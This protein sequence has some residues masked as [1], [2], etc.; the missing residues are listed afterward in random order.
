[1][2]K[3]SPHTK[4][5][6]RIQSIS[7]SCLTI[8]FVGLLSFSLS[9]HEA[10]AQT[11]A[12][13]T[14][15]PGDI[16][17]T[18]GNAGE[19]EDPGYA[20][21]H[22]A[23]VALRN[24][25]GGTR[26]GFTSSERWTGTGW[27]N[28]N[29]GFEG[30]VWTAPSG[31]IME[32]TEV[33][34]C[35]INDGTSGIARK[36]T[37]DSAIYR[38]ADYRSFIGGV[39]CGTWESAG[40]T[41]HLKG[42]HMWAYQP[43]DGSFLNDPRHLLCMGSDING[44]NGQPNSPAN[45]LIYDADN[46][47]GDFFD[48][49][50]SVQSFVFQT[51]Q[52]R[53]YGAV[54]ASP[55]GLIENG[56]TAGFIEML[57]DVEVEEA[58]QNEGDGNGN[59]GGG[60]G[61]G[62]GN[63]GNGGNTGNGG[64][65][66]SYVYYGNYENGVDSLNIGEDYLLF[67]PNG[68]FADYEGNFAWDSVLE[69]TGDESLDIYMDAPAAKLIVTGN[70][71]DS[72]IV[73]NLTVVNGTFQACD[74]GGKTAKIL[75]NITIKETGVY[76]GGK[77][78]LKITGS[79]QQ[80]LDASNY[81][82]P[83]ASNVAMKDVRLSNTAGMKVK[84]HVKFKAG[85]ALEF[86]Q[87]TFVEI[88]DDPNGDGTGS[89]N[90][91]FG[92]NATGTACIGP[93]DAS[94]FGDGE[95]QEF[96][97]QRYIPA[98]PDGS[99]WV[100]IGAYVKGTTVGDWTASNSN[101]LIF[102][103]NESN[104]GTQSAGW[105]YIWDASTVLEPGSGYMAILPAGEEALIDVTGAFVIGDLDI[106]LTFT[107]DPNQSDETVDGWNLVSNPYPSPVNLESVI[108][109]VDGVE[110]YWIYDNSGDGAYITRNDQGVGD[111]PSTLDVGQSFWVK[112]NTNQTLTFSES[113]KILA[114]TS[115]IREVDSGFEGAI[116]LEIANEDAQWCRTFVQFKEGATAAFDPSEDTQNYNTTSTQDLRVWTTADSGEKLSIQS[117][118]SLSETSSMP[119]KVT[120]GAG[121]LVR[122]TGFNQ[123]EAPTNVCTVIEDTETGE[124]AQ[125]GLDTLV[126]DLPAQTQFTD[127]FVLHFNATPS[128]T[129][130]STACDGLE[131][132]LSGEAWETWDASWSA[133]DGSAA[134][135]GM[136]YELEDGEYTFEFTL[137]DAGCVQS[138]DVTVETACLGDFNFNGERD[139]IDLLVILAGLPGGTL[140]SDFSEEADCDCDG[141]VTVND[142]LTFLTVFATTCD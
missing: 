20:E 57:N 55:A 42:K 67:G 132:E 115:F 39:E 60:N 56:L 11:Y 19:A 120:T 37:E 43:A 130:E 124:R 122:F 73:H 18:L 58:P 107:D 90:L 105:T 30:V 111:A 1:M 34:L 139:I 32:G 26:I 79:Q 86:D 74:G 75:G 119:L 142:M 85:G 54:T 95:L 129:W 38:S 89:S 14:L 92:S 40:N 5:N 136:P 123:E 114:S 49:E 41:K 133:N 98:D 113:D 94:N 121:G 91:I 97:F 13:T 126:V 93:C 24:L 110:A 16:W 17:M 116:G 138:V 48:D 69:D 82:T 28:D 9:F 31:G 99:T 29:A 21:L 68:N 65:N 81:D 87:G 35:D 25:E 137:A 8:S 104:Y 33:V 4:P 96:T 128:M 64:G 127:R 59:A 109:R 102:K 66:A 62:N 77:G 46:A 84:G 103:Y 36:A 72:V 117:V 70:G 27:S 78:K 44:T 88:D 15:S 22:V 100:N 140:Q 106:P 47:D 12:G 50:F 135:T 53:Y 10:G 131:I 134:G 2:A 51:T 101:M 3:T 141:A 71:I 7:V 108:S 61:N 52:W 118:G 80:T 45:T 23:F 112:V 76:N 6:W 125:L 63:N 83:S